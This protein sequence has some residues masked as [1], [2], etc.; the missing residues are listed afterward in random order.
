M[1]PTC[2]PFSPHLPPKAS[3]AVPGF[4]LVQPASV[5]ETNA[6]EVQEK[7]LRIY[8]PR[9][10]T[11]ECAR[12]DFTVSTAR[13]LR[14][15]LSDRLL[16]PELL[17]DACRRGSTPKMT[18]ARMAPPRMSTFHDAK[19]FDADVSTRSLFVE[20]SLAHTAKTLPGSL[21]PAIWPATA[22][23]ANVARSAPRLVSSKRSSGM[24]AS[25]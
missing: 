10:C 15:N 3:Q 23:C 1:W 20:R 8:I 7:S 17:P 6:D 24:S 5:N 16:A 4:K 21:E 13:S 11:A 19:E 18:P 14:R 9:I 2:V 25:C 22:G 12:Q